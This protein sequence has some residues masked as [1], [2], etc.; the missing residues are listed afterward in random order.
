MALSHKIAPVVVGQ[1]VPVGGP[2]PCWASVLD[3]KKI[4]PVVIKANKNKNL[5][6]F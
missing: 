2:S 4:V 6:F 3:G 1:Q 5:S